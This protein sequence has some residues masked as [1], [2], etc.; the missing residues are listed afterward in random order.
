[1]IL[2][3]NIFVK[4]DDIEKIA[5]WQNWSIGIYLVLLNGL[6]FLLFCVPDL[7]KDQDTQIFK[8]ITPAQVENLNKMYVQTLDPLLG[9]TGQNSTGRNLAVQ[10]ST[11]QNTA[12]VFRDRSFWQQALSFPFQGDLVQIEKNRT[13][14]Q[15]LDSMYSTSTQFRF[16]LS[17]TPTTP[18]AWITYQFVHAGFM[19]LLTNMFFLFLVTEYLKRRVSIN[20][21]IAV[22]ILGG[23]G[24][25]ISFLALTSSQSTA[26]VGASG[27]VCALIAFLAVVENRRVMPWSY[28]ISPMQQGYGLIYLPAFLL[29]PVYLLADFTAVLFNADGVSQ[30]VAHSAHIGGALSGG[31]L[32]ACYLLGKKL[33]RLSQ[34][35]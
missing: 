23:I 24:A 19:H 1:M 7:I 14:L 31:L 8:S 18:W 28:F 4:K 13:L 2:P 6:V 9:S 16:G 10:N 25:G 33:N 30:S 22:Y 17:Q 21:I 15:K 29:F 20:W 5:D 35:N 26:M 34:A 3:G 11:I 32:A 12:Q 27:A